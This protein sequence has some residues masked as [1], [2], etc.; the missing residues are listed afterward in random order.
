M[1]LCNYWWKNEY[2]KYIKYCTQSLDLWKA[3]VSCAWLLGF[4]KFVFVLYQMQALSAGSKFEAEIREEKEERKR[5][6]EE[7]KQRHAAFKQLQSTFCS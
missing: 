2:I 7:K 1:Q 5:Q 4:K 6:E 3:A